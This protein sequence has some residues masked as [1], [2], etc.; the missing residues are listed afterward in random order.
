MTAFAEPNTFRHL[1]AELRHYGIDKQNLLALQAYL[2]NNPLA[3]RQFESQKALLTAYARAIESSPAK[4]V[5]LTR[6]FMS[7]TMRQRYEIER[8]WTLA[9]LES[10]DP[11]GQRAVA[12]LHDRQAQHT[13]SVM[14]ADGAID[15]LA[16]RTVEMVRSSQFQAQLR[17]KEASFAK[18]ERF[19]YSFEAPLIAE[20]AS[21]PTW[22]RSMQQK[23][24]EFFSHHE[25]SSRYRLVSVDCRTT[26]C[27]LKAEGN[28]EEKP[29][30]A[31]AQVAY[32]FSQ[33]RWGL[34]RGGGGA[35][36]SP[37]E[38]VYQMRERLERT[39][40]R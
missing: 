11:R 20:E 30:E 7:D 19:D 1:A 16:A 29:Y 21:D 13:T 22:S 12:A 35:G 9:L 8:S 3:L 34:R 32:E 27:E 26:Y 10:L 33:K 4:S 39:D 6:A 37:A 5:E 31:F 23:L 14:G 15:E 38:S 28:Y 36:P 18:P 17:A 40:S 2:S 25:L 24:E